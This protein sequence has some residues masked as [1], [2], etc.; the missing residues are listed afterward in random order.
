MKLISTNIALNS[1]LQRLIRKYENISFGTAWA[2]AETDVFAELAKAKAKIAKG[3]IGTHF[4]QTHP[5]VLDEFVGSCQVSF[6][7]QPEGVFHPK[8]FAFWTAKSWEILIGSAN[9]TVGALK[10]NTEL[11]ILIS[12]KDGTPDLLDEVLAAIDGYEGRTISQIDADN[13]RR[14][15]KLKAPI[16]DK[17][18]GSYGGNPATKPEVES[19]VMT[20]D[21]PAFYAALQKDKAHGFTDRL[22]MLDQ[23]ANEFAK[24]Q[25][26]NDIPFQE[27]L[28]IAGLRSKA[29]KNSEW[30]GSMVGAGKF[31]KLINSSEP[32]F[33]VA[34]DAIPPTGAVTRHQYDT[35]I[36]EYLKA[37]PNG[38]DGLGTATRL[39]SMK[40]PDTF[41][42]VDSA[43][44]KKLAQ[45]VGM[46]RPDKLDY[47]R[48]WTEVV[49]RL[50]Q[51]PWWQ[52]PEPKQQS[53]V[54]AWR[55][56]TAMLDAIF[57]EA[58]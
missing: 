38:R 10:A 15:W 48:Y 50:Q 23:V 34:L 53:E 17:L 31:Y 33:S 7:L 19:P 30:F 55:A 35:F 25:S 22:S 36:R 29:I 20:M 8:V 37:F 46:K 54:R 40:R 2:S 13:Y 18:K 47:E 58:K 4:Y 14:I 43:N 45:D 9:L 24:A 12:H 21:W 57:Y 44:L 39:L 42:C 56:R 41:L 51:A 5:D 28:G 16:K 52:S 11:S 32:A 49:E 3:V 26:F 6:V 1:N 27:R